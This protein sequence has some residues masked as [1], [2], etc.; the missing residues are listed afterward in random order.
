[1]LATKSLPSTL[2][3]H[4]LW[5]LD[6]ADGGWRRAEI[7]LGDCVLLFTSLDAL[8]EFLNQCGD[9]DGF[10]AEAECRARPVVYSRSRKEFGRRARQALRAG[11]VGGLIDPDPRTGEAPFLRFSRLGR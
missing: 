1:M 11:F 7:Q 4:V 6:S 5:T 10:D 9:G 8:Q 2:F 3:D